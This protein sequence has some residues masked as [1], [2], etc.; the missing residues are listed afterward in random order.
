MVSFITI[1]IVAAAAVAV[2]HSIISG[3]NTSNNS[4][5]IA[6]T[7]AA[8]AAA[9]NKCNKLKFSL[10]SIPIFYEE[11]NPCKHEQICLLQYRK[12][13]LCSSDK[14]V[15]SIATALSYPSFLPVSVVGC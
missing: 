3:S 8:A 15:P 14:G 2:V 13:P 10:E 11:L 12:L 4:S 5:R 9:A 6:T 7:T 1:I